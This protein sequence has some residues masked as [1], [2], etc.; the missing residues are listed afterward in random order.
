MGRWITLG[1]IPAIPPSLQSRTVRRGS[2]EVCR[3]TLYV[4]PRLQAIEIS[5]VW[6]IP[7]VLGSHCFPTSISI[8]PPSPI[9]TD[10][11][12][13]VEPAKPVFRSQ[14]ARAGPAPTKDEEVSIK[15]EFQLQN[16]FLDPLSF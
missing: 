4:A 1:S 15:W 16:K 2:C 13:E 14:A 3:S 6:S 9:E 12:E 10:T 8:P 7:S 5:G 11:S